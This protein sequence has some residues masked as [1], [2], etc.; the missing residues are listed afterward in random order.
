MNDM[1]LVS[2]MIATRIRHE[3]LSI[4]LKELCRQNYKNLEVIVIDDASTP[5]IN[6]IVLMYWPEAH[7][8]SH[9]KNSGQNI[10]RNEGFKVAK[11][12]YILHLDDDC[13]P[14]NS[15]AISKSVFYMESSDR[16][17]GIAYYVWNG[18]SFPN[19]IDTRYIVSGNCQSYLG[20]A[21]L[22]RKSAIDETCG[23]RDIFAHTG[24][25]EELSL[26]LLKRGWNISYRPEIV[27]H[28]RYSTQNR[29]KPN[30]WKYALRNRLWTIL[31]HMPMPRLFIEIVWKL[32]VGF[33][34]AFRLRRM[35]LYY[36]AV[37]ESIIGI[38]E[39]WKLRDPLDKVQLRRYDYLRAYGVLPYDLFEDPPSMRFTYLIRWAKRW[40]NRLREG[41]FY[42]KKSNLG[43]GEYPTHEHELER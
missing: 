15:D 20:A 34:D 5:S 39:I 33:W 30:V 37:L 7:I 17:A 2:I 28:H 40:P 38:S 4:T 24:E 12:K 43:Y 11:G 13:S 16:C 27:A 10:R 6:S 1:P 19:N 8:L 9:T 32:F 31:L 18:K 36:N 42:S 35:A 23:Y 26:Q 25:E 29:S 3:D 14:V 21:V 22:L 41:S